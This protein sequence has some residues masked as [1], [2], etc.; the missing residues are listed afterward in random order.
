M[1]LNE[2]KSSLKNEGPPDAWSAYL[3]ALW[4]E[5][6]GN[7]EMA[8]NLVQDLTTREAAWI[9]AYLH[10]KEGDRSNANYWYN[11]AGKTMPEY[12]LPE[13]WEKLVQAFL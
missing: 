6:N 13:E 9:H 3:K 4:H 2:F 8:H 1:T 5:G 7:W 12:P 11:R 10:R